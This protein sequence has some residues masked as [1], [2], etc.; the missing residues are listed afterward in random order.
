MEKIIEIKNMSFKYDKDFIL[1]NINLDVFR[2]DFLGIVGSN[3]AGKS[4]LI[5]LILGQLKPNSGSLN[6]FGSP[7]W[8]CKKIGRVGYVAQ[9]GLS[10]GMDFPATVG[11]IVMLNMYREVGM[12]RF[13]KKEHIEAV[14]RALDTVG[15]LDYINRSFS[16]L[17]GGQQQ[18]VIIAKAIVNQ[19]EVLILDEPTSGI[20]HRSEEILYQLLDRLNKEE[21]IT[22]LMISHDLN[23]IKLHSNRLIELDSFEKEVN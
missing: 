1:K 17:S 11:E 5:K 12:F 14:R 16:D 10:R 20:D 8:S 13:P 19:P 6:L 3:G 18:R 23:K 4:T 22:I 7:A 9:I 2:G 21:N 15:M